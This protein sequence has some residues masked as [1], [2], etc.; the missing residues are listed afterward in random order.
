MEKVY[1]L[2]EQMQPMK[3]EVREGSIQYIL[4]ELKKNSNNIPFKDEDG[5]FWGGCAI[6]IT[7]DG[8]R[9]PE[10]AANPYSDV[11]GIIL[12]DGEAVVETEDGEMKLESLD[13]DE[14]FCLADYIHDTYY[15]YKD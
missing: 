8:G 6:C 11:N 13:W 12:E 1:E 7:Y 5:E 15:K 9:H 4:D 10:Y 2:W 3:K 14:I